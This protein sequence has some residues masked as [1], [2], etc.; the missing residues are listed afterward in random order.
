LGFTAAVA[1][2]LWLVRA[3]WRSSH[4]GEDE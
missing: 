1:C 2:G 3:I 4:R